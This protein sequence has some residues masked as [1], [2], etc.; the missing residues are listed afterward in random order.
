MKKNV[1]ILLLFSSILSYAQTK[2]TKLDSLKEINPDSI[3]TI[4]DDPP[5]FIGGQQLLFKFLAM[6]VRYPAF[7]RENAIEGTIYV[8]FV[9]DE[10]G[11]IVDVT[12]K[13]SK[14]FQGFYDKKKKKWILTD[15]KSDESLNTESVRVVQAMP[16]WKPG[17]MKGKKVRVAYTLP[18]K[19][20]LE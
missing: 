7:A 4:V 13:G 12:V 6:N 18:V 5:E 3:F 16:K 20:K 8:G 15:V 19:Y 11:S 9:V 17:S 10:K 1:L 2:E 14:L